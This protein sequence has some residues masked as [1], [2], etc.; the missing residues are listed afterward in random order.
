MNSLGSNLAPLGSFP[1]ITLSA[2]AHISVGNMPFLHS[3]P[4]SRWLSFGGGEVV[5][6]VFDHVLPELSK[7][8]DVFQ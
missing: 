8:Q 5:A 2:L 1:A 3:H 7:R 6:Y 4:R